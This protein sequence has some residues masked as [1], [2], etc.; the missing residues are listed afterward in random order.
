MRPSIHLIPGKKRLCFNTKKQ[1]PF[2]DHQANNH[3]GDSHKVKSCSSFIYHGKSSYWLWFASFTGKELLLFCFH[4][5][6]GSNKIAFIFKR[7]PSFCRSSW[8]HFSPH[9]YISRVG[10]VVKA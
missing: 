5:K 10:P 3:A 4:V 9:K 6:R 8:N 2:G 7:Q 1:K